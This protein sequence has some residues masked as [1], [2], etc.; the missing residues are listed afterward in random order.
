[1]TN[2]ENAKKQAD[3][4]DERIINLISQNN[5]VKI[6]AGA[7]AGKTYSLHKVIDWFILNKI[8][9]L[10]RQQR[11]IAC[12]T[13]TNAAVEV[14]KQR[15]GNKKEIVPSTIHSFAWE[16]IKQFQSTM[17]DTVLQLNLISES[18]R[19][20]FNKITYSLGVRYIEDGILYLH[21]NDVLKIFI[22]FLD[23]VKFRKILQSKYSAILIDEYQDSNK[24]I[25]HKF[26]Q[27]FIETDSEIQICLFG[28]AWQTIYQTNNACG[29][30][31][32]E[33]I[34]V[35]GKTVNF[36]S[37]N[38]I[39]VLLNKIR[40]SLPQITAIDD[41]VG[42]C[43]VVDCNDYN[44]ER[45]LDGQF[46][47]DLPI[48]ILNERLKNIEEKMTIREESIKTLMIT[49]KMLASHQGY[50]NLLR[51]MDDRL[52]DLTDVLFTFVVDV[53]ENI[54]ESFEGKKIALLHDTLK[55]KQVPI[56]SKSD[57]IKWNKLFEGMS[58]KRNESIFEILELV[59]DS[60]IVPVPI[61]ILNIYNDMKNNPDKV[62][63]KG[64]I[65][66]LK[67][68]KY[69]EFVAAKE[70]FKPNS[71]Y[72]T[73]HGVKGEEYDN[74]IF[75]ISK[76]WNQY[77]FDKYLPMSSNGVLENDIKS[78]ERNRNLFY[79]GCSRA[80]K[81]LCL[82]VTHKVED[83]FKQYLKNLFGEDNYFTYTEFLNLNIN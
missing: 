13:Y 32:N 10:N 4:L 17:I 76:G 56:S 6:E 15:L 75:V 18:E 20:E 22:S 8:K 47:G 68:I 44:G 24:D 35:I 5:H 25:M 34:K 80:K 36:R 71:I 23:N 66:E 3:E 19:L 63:G 37:A 38:A 21:H 40:P 72:S 81:R 60:K 67:N 53:I 9:E 46:R 59:I 45:R 79:V 43:Y 1:M 73:D 50:D 69:S 65:S 12:I 11:K 61:E 54:Y 14:I 41:F 29:E 26:I 55:T 57:K 83:N 51:I 27:Y 62:Y 39:V 58:K 48:E 52:K 7:G 64:K 74:I 82:F 70:F 77:Q 28:D 30:I 78:F 16:N 33:R 42:E 31:N 2:Y 49:H